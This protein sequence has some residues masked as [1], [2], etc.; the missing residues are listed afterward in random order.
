MKPI[1]LT[2]ASLV[3]VLF[4]LLAA[5][6]QTPTPQ[7]TPEVEADLALAT[8]SV[9]PGTVAGW[10]NNGVGQSTI[11]TDLNNVVAIAAGDSHSLALTDLEPNATVLLC[12]PHIVY[13]EG[14]CCGNDFEKP[15]PERAS[16]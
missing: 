7:A 14:S 12:I 10:G 3:A 1:R 8:Q 4:L 6:Q 13:N 5:C 16:V 15:K 9:T 11:P 2:L